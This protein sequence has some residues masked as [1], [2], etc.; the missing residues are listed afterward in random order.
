MA[1]GK[2]GGGGRRRGGAGG[3][4]EKFLKFSVLDSWNK[5]HFLRSPCRDEDWLGSAAARPLLLASPPRQLRS[6]APVA[7]GRQAPKEQPGEPSLGGRAWEKG[8]APPL[9]RWDAAPVVLTANLEG[10]TESVSQLFGRRK[11][12]KKKRVAKKRGISILILVWMCGEMGGCIGG[13]GEGVVRRGVRRW[14]KRE[15]WQSDGDGEDVEKEREMAGMRLETGRRG[16]KGKREQRKGSRE[17]KG[18]R[19]WGRAAEP[20]P[21]CYPIATTLT[22][23]S[24]NLEVREHERE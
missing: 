19:G 6:L 12:Q 23:G 1:L 9:P 8:G 7:P 22:P 20:P 5:S 18:T 15:G 4:A 16:R 2:Q 17:M 24:F 3:K 14:E 10:R 21:H 11:R 13:E